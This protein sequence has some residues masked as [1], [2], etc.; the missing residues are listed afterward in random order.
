MGIERHVHSRRIA[1]LDGWRGLSLLL[2]LAGHFAPANRLDL[3]TLG[4]EAFFVLSGRLIIGIL[5]VERSPLPLFVKR[6]VSRIFPGL[7]VFV[8]LVWLA[9]RGSP[10]GFKV[11]AL[12]SALT[13]TLNYAMV[14]RHGVEAIEN[15][16][17]LCIE[18]HVYVLLGALAFLARRKAVDARCASVRQ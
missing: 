18:E 12:A 16:W 8:L 13:F 14:F 9:A 1:F 5:F 10:Y 7:A 6:R 3:A 17:S 15:L 4:V 11:S 2:V